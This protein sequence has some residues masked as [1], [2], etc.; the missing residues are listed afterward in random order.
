MSD[1]AN[2]VSHV[3]QDSG[4]F[5]L[6]SKVTLLPLLQVALALH[7]FMDFVID[8]GEQECQ[9]RNARRL[10]GEQS[11]MQWQETA[12]L[13]AAFVL[14][15]SAKMGSRETLSQVTAYPVIMAS[16]QDHSQLGL[17]MHNSN[18]M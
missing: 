7:T 14:S 6:C 8:I 9:R 16:W 3:P 18:V 12:H 1:F 17:P 4:I 15:A 2:C 5:L 13:V 11:V 10:L